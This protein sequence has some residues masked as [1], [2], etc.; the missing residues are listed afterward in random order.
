MIDNPADYDYW[1]NQCCDVLDVIDLSQ[2]T[3]EQLTAL[4]MYLQALHSSNELASGAGKSRHLR[5]I[6]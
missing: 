4:T 2:C 3:A 5:L 1:L 6:E